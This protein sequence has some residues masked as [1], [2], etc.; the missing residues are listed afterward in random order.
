[1]RKLI[2]VVAA[3]GALGGCKKNKQ[4]DSKGGTTAPGTSAPKAPMSTADQDALWALAPDNMAFGA[5]I[6]PAGVGKLEAGALEIKKLLDSPELAMFK[7]KADEAL[8][9]IFG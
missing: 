5:V 4:A 2:V 6:S 3:L 9:D 7:A 8:T 1:M